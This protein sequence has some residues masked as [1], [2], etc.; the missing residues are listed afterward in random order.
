MC[1]REKSTEIP[2]FQRRKGLREQIVPI[3]TKESCLVPDEVK[4]AV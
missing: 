4:L 1:L 2:I 3:K